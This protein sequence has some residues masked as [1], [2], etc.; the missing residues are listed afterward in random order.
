MHTHDRL[1]PASSSLVLLVLVG[2]SPGCTRGVETTPATPTPTP[3]AQNVEVPEWVAE[4]DWPAI[5][6][7]AITLTQTVTTQAPWQG[8]VSSLEDRTL[9]CPDFYTGPFT[10]ATELVGHDDGIAWND[11]C[12]TTG[13]TSFDGWLWWDSSVVEAG[14]PGTDDGRTADATRTVEGDALVNAGDGVQF[15]FEGTASDSL[16]RLDAYGYERFTYATTIDGTVGGLDAFEGTLTPEGYRTDLFMYLTG[17]DV[18]TFEA[19]GNIYLF[20]PQLR[21]RFDSVQVDLFLPGPNGAGPEDCTLEP[22][23]WLGVRDADALW[24]DVVFL[25]RFEEDIAEE[26]YD[27]ELRSACDGCGR[28]YIQG[29]EQPEVEICVDFSFL[30]DGSFTLPDPDDYVLP[31]HSL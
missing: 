2:L 7:D 23:G 3:V 28:L 18:D 4:V 11:D 8:H 13:G 16:Y 25:P 9:G 27:D 17:G 29:I 10:V 22:L 20:T 21:E 5:F 12:Q 26:P 19:R 15:T 31:L 30:F 14:D 1:H 6:Q 24:Y